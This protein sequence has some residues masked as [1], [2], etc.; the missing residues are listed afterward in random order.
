MTERKALKAAIS[1]LEAQ[2]LSWVMRFW[3]LHLINAVQVSRTRRN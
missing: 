2:R 1:V 3:M